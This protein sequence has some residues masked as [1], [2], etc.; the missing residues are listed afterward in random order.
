MAEKSSRRRGEPNAA[1]APLL[2]EGKALRDESR[3]IARAAQAE[4][5]ADDPPTVQTCKKHLSRLF[6]FPYQKLGPRLCA[7]RLATTEDVSKRLDR[8]R[9][10]A[11]A[12]LG[13]ARRAVIDCYKRADYLPS[14]D[15]KP[16]ARPAGPES[17]GPVV[18]TTEDEIMGLGGVRRRGRRR[19][20]AAL[21]PYPPEVE[22]EV[23][24]FGATLRRFHQALAPAP[25]RT[26]STWPPQARSVVP[27]R[28]SP[29]PARCEGALKLALELGARVSETECLIKNR[30]VEAPAIRIG[31]KFLTLPVETDTV[32]EQTAQQAAQ[33]GRAVR[34]CLHTAVRESA[35][36]RGR[37]HPEWE[38]TPEE[39]KVALTRTKRPPFLEF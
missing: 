19:G 38:M 16:A 32:F 4:G 18:A 13:A 25:R 3:A 35:I 20:L 39:Q 12:N 34:D 7:A 15:N 9:S 17:E 33:S 22:R 11:L 26:V 1:L 30:R 31:G 37:W 10:V 29:S 23:R 14:E 27:E 2:Q 24:A 28:S 8:Y 36:H 6:Q 21:A 5:S